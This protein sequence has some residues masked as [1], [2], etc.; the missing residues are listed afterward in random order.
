MVE[1]T[2]RARN[3]LGKTGSP[4]LIAAHE[5]EDQIR[6]AL[7]ALARLH[8]ARATAHGRRS[9]PDQLT[10]PARY[11]FLEEAVLLMARKGQ[12]RILTLDVAGEP[13]AAQLVL[14][15]PAASYLSFSGIDPAWW[16]VSGVTMLHLR[17]AEDAIERGHRSLSLSVGPSVYKLRWSER[18]RQNP[19]FIVC[20]RRL[21]SRIAYTGYRMAA[22]AAGIHREAVRHQVSGSRKQVLVH[23]LQL[24]DFYRPVI[25][26]LEKHV[27]SLSMELQSLGHTAVVVTLQADGLPAEETIDGVRVIR[28][29]SWSQ[30]LRRCYADLTRPFHPTAPDQ[31]AVSALRAVI[32]REKPDVVHSHSWIQYSFFPLYRPRTGPAHVVTLHDYGLS[33]A[34]KTLQRSGQVEQCAG[35]RLTRCLSCA[36]QQ[37][38]IFKGTMTATAL[39]ASRFLHDRADHYIA[40]SHAVAEGSRPGLPSNRKLTVVPTMVP[41]DLPGVAASTPRPDFLPPED[42]YLMFVGALGGHKGV[43]VLLEAKRR[44]RHQV[45]LVLIGTPQVDT[46]PI[47]DQ[48]ITVVTNVPNA[49]VMASWARASVAVIPSVWHEPMGQVAVE[50]MLAGRPVVASDVG[51]LR[52]VVEHGRTGLRVPPGNPAALAAALDRLLDDPGLRHAMGEV[53]RERARRFEVAQVAPR[54][55]EVFAEALLDRARARASSR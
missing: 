53:G 55:V 54:V 18:I 25:G 5:D 9:H 36:P 27:E 8:A 10:V 22:T 45:P 24:T 43:D 34:R 35:P 51:G 37:Y 1:S 6:Y 32:E 44:M 39:R 13:V 19:E 7:P 42:G 40:V 21:S 46:P 49:Q 20:G 4:W 14:M 28:V 3:R 41:N 15:T 26:G 29:K 16:H 47:A 33:C 52:D 23:I 48:A 38:G 11:A 12:A 31:G 17:A 2:H 30:N 50:A